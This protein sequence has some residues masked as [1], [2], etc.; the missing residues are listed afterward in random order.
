MVYSQKVKKIHFFQS[1]FWQAALKSIILS[2]LSLSI[3]MAPNAPSAKEG[4]QHHTDDTSTSKP[5]NQPHDMG[6]S[7]SNNHVTH[8]DIHRRV[9]ADPDLLAAIGATRRREV[10]ADRAGWRAIASGR[11]MPR[12]LGPPRRPSP[13]CSPAR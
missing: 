8:P 10:R 9:V 5:V 2:F 11:A 12:S 7:D 13:A 6:H 1:N 4:H 3:I